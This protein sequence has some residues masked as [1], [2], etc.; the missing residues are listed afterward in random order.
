MLSRNKNE[1]HKV[2]IR[3]PNLSPFHFIFM[4]KRSG[5]ICDPTWGSFPVRGSFAVQF[6]DHFRSE[7][8]LWAGIICGPVQGQ[9]SRKI[10]RGS[11]ERQVLY[12]IM[13]IEETDSGRILEQKERTCQLLILGFVDIIVIALAISR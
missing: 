11:G 7:D 3:C 12:I 5:I 10:D 4:V 1:F 6:G 13:I 2:E 8:H 9:G